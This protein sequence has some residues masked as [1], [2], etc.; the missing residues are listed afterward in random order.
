MHAWCATIRTVL[1]QLIMLDELKNDYRNPVDFCQNLNR[2]KVLC[3]SLW[4]F[5]NTPPIYTVGVAWIWHSSWGGCHVTCV[6]LLVYLLLQHTLAGL[7]YMEVTVWY[8]F[9][10][11]INCVQWMCCAGTHSVQPCLV[12]ASMTPQKLWTDL[13]WLYTQERVLWRLDSTSYLSSS[14]STSRLRCTVHSI[15]TE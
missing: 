2:V 11:G 13:N 15:G 3:G 7:P 10:G 1:L 4:T 5:C 12:P 8:T 6:W 9:W 14:I